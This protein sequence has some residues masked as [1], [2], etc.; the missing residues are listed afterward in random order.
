MARGISQ[1]GPKTGEMLC[2]Y[3][4][5]IE[6]PAGRGRAVQEAEAKRCTEKEAEAERCKSRQRQSGARGRGQAFHRE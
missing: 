5:V 3:V 2:F 4:F 1:A 6:K